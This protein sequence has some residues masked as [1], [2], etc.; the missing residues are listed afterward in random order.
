MADLDEV[1]EARCGCWC[2]RGER[3]WHCGCCATCCGC[4]HA[5]DD[6]W[7]RPDLEVVAPVEPDAGDAG[8]KGDGFHHGDVDPLVA[9]AQRA[10]FESRVEIAAAAA[11]ARLR[12]PR[13]HRAT[14]RRRRAS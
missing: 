8:G 5:S 7:R 14:E 10:A 13:L 4:P 9:R 2:A 3:C 1:I 6:D 12:R 11:A